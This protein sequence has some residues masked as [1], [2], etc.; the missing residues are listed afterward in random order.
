MACH[1]YRLSA[2]WLATRGIHHTAPT[3]RDV[4]LC[5]PIIIKAIRDHSIA[6]CMELT[7]A[8]TITT[9]FGSSRLK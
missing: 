8:L 1:L 4:A 2:V 3:A 6:D 9:A 5:T 7:E